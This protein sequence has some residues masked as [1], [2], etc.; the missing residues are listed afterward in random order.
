MS[1]GRT[2]P[3]PTDVVLIGAGAAGGTAA[4][5][6]TEAGVNVVCLERG[7]WI[8]PEEFSGDEIK[9]INRNFLW[10]DTLLKPRTKRSD[11]SET[12]EV[13][14][15]SPTPQMVGGGT[16]H[17]N[18]WFPRPTPD[19]LR[20]RSIYGD[21]PGATLVDWPFSYDDLEPYLTKVEWEFGASGLAGSN[22]YDGYRSAGFPCPPVPLSGYGKAFYKGCGT[23][24][25]NAFPLPQALVTTAHKGRKA[26]VHSGFWQEYGDPT[27]TKSTT[28]QS[29]IPEA[30]ATGRL[31]LRPESYVREITVGK[32]GR[33]NG[34]IYVD[35]DGREI[36]QRASAVVVCCGGIETARLL[37]MSKSNLFPDGLANNN[38]LVGRNFTAHEYI[39]AVGVFDK[40][41]HP[42]L[43]GWSGSY[44]NGATYE[45]YKTD[46]N[47]PHILG[48]VVS[49]S[50]LGH[51]VNYNFPGKPTWGQ[52][53]KDADRDFFNHS[54]KVGVP[55]Q[56]LPQHTNMVD[57]DPEVRDAWGMP[58]AR[59]TVKPHANDLAQ[60][61]WIV[62]KCVDILEA[63]GASS[64]MPVYMNDITGNCNHEMGTTRMGNDP[65]TSVLN[66]WGQ[67]HD[68]DN[69]YVMDGSV[70]PTSLGVNPT[71]T[72]MAIA[73]RCAERLAS[74][75]GERGV[76]QAG[77]KLVHA[78]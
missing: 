77:K 64:V 44:I 27:T 12:A 1:V 40:E 76:D 45:F 18:G 6:L 52:A 25:H 5:V 59:I 47:R 71:L 22:K 35:K 74:Q 15:F 21:I 66:Q 50:I 23:L 20:P 61:A 60:G 2:T 14:R 37:L 9:Y 19:D 29:F 63:G 4:K 30:L 34:V 41:N 13:T 36:H 55:V 7:P 57:L 54:M 39:F 3:D 11:A 26:S 42:P 78:G 53:G 38:G 51:P 67:A 75:R 8:K 69:L 48:A 10:Q 31:D 70:F 17:W 46:L 28:L 73:W 68:V 24:G 33:A 62:D 56:D 32:D 72:I 49:G 58:V 43:R 16:T 65:A